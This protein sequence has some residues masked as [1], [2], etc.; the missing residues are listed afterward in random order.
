MKKTKD[1]LFQH[2]IS[3]AWPLSLLLWLAGCGG[4]MVLAPVEQDE[5][6]VTSDEPARR[7]FYHIVAAGETLY[8]IAWLY[9]QDYQ[10]VAA[11]NRLSSPDRI[12]AGQRLRV[13]PP[14]SVEV[15]KP[16]KTIS[17][18]ARPTR[19][20]LPPVATP[21][22]LIAPIPADDND[23]PTSGRVLWKWPATG[24][25]LP[26]RSGSEKGISIAGREGQPV[27]AAAAGRVVY[28]GNGLKGLGE[29]V[30]VKHDK[31][32]LSAYANNKKRLVKEGE[33]VALGQPIA[34]MGKST[35]EQVQLYF[36]I[37]KDGKPVDPLQYLPRNRQ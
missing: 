9:G 2:P 32:F 16:V 29:L 10:Q 30:I 7:D 19:P 20:V 8:A 1:G 26:E 37:R 21:A 27:R 24:Q 22:P 14:D 25:V 13:T 36:E 23:T 33:K 35:S 15:S 12:Y 3:A 31:S 11:W 17:A 34:E 28:S 5:D 6:A 18:P 4:P